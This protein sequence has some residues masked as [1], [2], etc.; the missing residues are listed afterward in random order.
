MN[1]DLSWVFEKSHRQIVAVM[2]ALLRT[3]DGF[4]ERR[5]WG[6]LHRSSYARTGIG[7]PVMSSNRGAVPPGFAVAGPGWLPHLAA[8]SELM[9]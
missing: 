4:I 2:L 7:I 8:E 6:A 3:E 1:R 9:S 5:P